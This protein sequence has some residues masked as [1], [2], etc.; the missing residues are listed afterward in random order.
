MAEPRPGRFSAGQF[1]GWAFGS[2]IGT[3]LGYLPQAIIIRLPIG[4]MNRDFADRFASDLTTGLTV[5]GAFIGGGLGYI[6]SY[7]L[8]APKFMRRKIAAAILYSLTLSLLIYSVLSYPLLSFIAD[9]L[10]HRQFLF[11]FL[12]FIASFVAACSKGVLNNIRTEGEYPFGEDE[13][14]TSV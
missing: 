4:A 2:M 6:F 5:W 14:R 1:L 11:P 7:I 12:A 8:D 13:D 10:S 9:D 3:S